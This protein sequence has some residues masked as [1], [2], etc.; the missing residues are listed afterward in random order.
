MTARPTMTETPA[1]RFRL[2]VLAAGVAI[3]LLM[4]VIDFDGPL[5]WGLVLLSV[6]GVLALFAS[7][8]HRVISI[9]LWLIRRPRRGH[10]DLDQAIAERWAKG[11]DDA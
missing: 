4:P 9:I 5:G 6:V 10:A 3:L 2:A 8:Y 11:D 1:N 7:L